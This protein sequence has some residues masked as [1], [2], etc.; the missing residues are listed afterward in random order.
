MNDGGDCFVVAG[1]YVLE[2]PNT[3]LVHGIVKGQGQ[4]TDVLF[5]HA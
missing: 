4:L 1:H 5:P 3:I 2:H